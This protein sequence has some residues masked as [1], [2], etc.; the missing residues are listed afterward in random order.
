MTIKTPEQMEDAAITDAISTVASLYAK[1]QRRQL[2]NHLQSALK[3]HVD[4]ARLKGREIDIAKF[5]Q[6]AL[7]IA[8]G[9]SEQ[10]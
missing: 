9:F 8:S 10:N 2:V 5:T 6:R 3:P 1:E 7:N 4:E